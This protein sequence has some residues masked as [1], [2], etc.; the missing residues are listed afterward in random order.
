MFVSQDGNSHFKYVVL[1]YADTYFVQ[2]RSDPSQN[3][4]DADV[5]KIYTTVP[6]DKLESKL[7]DIIN[8]CLFHKNGNRR[9]QY[10]VHG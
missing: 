9:F 10:V 3:Y 2:G 1:G 4:S 8:Q 7:R 5:V 6:H